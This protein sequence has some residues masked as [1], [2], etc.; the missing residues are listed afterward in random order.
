VRRIQSC[1][2]VPGGVEAA[3]L[4]QRRA[5]AGQR[6]SQDL[7]RLS[8]RPS[9]TGHNNAREHRRAQVPVR[10]RAESA[11]S[12]RA[13]VADRA[14]YLSRRVSP[15]HV[16]RARR[17]AWLTECLAAAGVDP[18]VASS[19][20][21]TL[22]P[23]STIGPFKNELIKPRDLAHLRPGRDRHREVQGVVR[24][25]LPAKRRHGSTN[26]RLRNPAPTIKPSRLR[27]VSTQGDSDRLGDEPGREAG[28]RKPRTRTPAARFRAGSRGA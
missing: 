15:A 10:R 12:S 20:S 8:S 3:A 28:V 4:G 7:S 9:S 24:P 18:S 22:W 19:P 23:E 5:T 14:Q 21:P 17:D 27:H 16:A 25:P 6:D 26:S 13:Q 1:H 2:A 11:V